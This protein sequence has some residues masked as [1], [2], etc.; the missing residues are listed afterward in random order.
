MPTDSPTP[1]SSDLEKEGSAAR[2]TQ[3]GKGIKYGHNIPVDRKNGGQSG[4]FQFLLI[5]EP[6]LPPDKTHRQ[7]VRTHV[8]RN[9]HSRQR[10]LKSGLPERNRKISKRKW[11]SEAQQSG[12]VDHKTPRDFPLRPLLAK[13]AVTQPGT[14]NPIL[15][16]E[17]PDLTAYT[18]REAPPD[19][20]V[21]KYAISSAAP[22]DFLARFDQ[23]LFNTSRYLNSLPTPLT[24]HKASSN[25]ISYQLPRTH[26]YK[27]MALQHSASR[28]RHGRF[29]NRLGDF[30]LKFRNGCPKFPSVRQI[31][32]LVGPACTNPLEYWHI[33]RAALNTS[34]LRLQPLDGSITE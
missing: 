25:R 23:W 20:T 8:M 21:S 15:P 12:A 2:S 22:T 4:A 34:L 14:P 11:I 18:P 33:L 10:N 27:L 30:T 1:L 9:Y 24:F 6:F 7:A 5:N 28:P 17:D 29:H 13:T 32:K 31:R 3:Q 16:D 26:C 19:E